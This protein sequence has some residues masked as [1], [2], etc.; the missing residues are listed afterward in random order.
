MR[1]SAVKERFY[2]SEDTSIY[3][4]FPYQ[5]REFGYHLTGKSRL[6]SRHRTRKAAEAS[7]DRAKRKAIRSGESVWVEMAGRDR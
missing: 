1:A 5:L 7:Y 3:Y 2:I 6:I 4:S